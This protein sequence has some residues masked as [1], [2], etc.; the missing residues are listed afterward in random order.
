MSTQTKRNQDDGVERWHLRTL[1]DEGETHAEIT[2]S[3]GNGWKGEE[4]MCLGGICSLKRARIAAAAPELLAACQ[5]ALAEALAYC[6]EE[7]NGDSP[8]GEIIRRLRAAIAKAEGSG[9]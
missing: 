6:G 5:F 1:Q 9:A 8:N 7:E 4:Y 2:L 3:P